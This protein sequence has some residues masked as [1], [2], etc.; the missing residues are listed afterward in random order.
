[1]KYF[2]DFCISYWRGSLGMARIS[3]L[4][5]TKSVI[6]AIIV[7]HMFKVIPSPSEE[8]MAG[9]IRAAL[10]YIGCFALLRFVR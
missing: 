2:S 1:M 10:A 9:A 6:K 7:G 8:V 3:G 4:K 5:A